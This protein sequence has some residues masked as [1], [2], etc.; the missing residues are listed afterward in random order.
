MTGTV[1]ISRALTNSLLLI[2]V[3]G[4]PLIGS[5]SLAAVKEPDATRYEFL[6]RNKAEDKAAKLRAQGQSAQVETHQRNVIYRTLQLRVFQDWS[7]AKRIEARLRE[8]GIDALVINDPYERGYAVSAG[9]F[10]T[11]EN[12]AQQERKL[13]ELGYRQLAV[14]PMRGALTRYVVL[15]APQPE[16]TPKGAGADARSCAR[17]RGSANPAGGKG[18]RGGCA[19]G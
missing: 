1:G 14:V 15:A 10:L 18:A 19:L 2:A 13:R 4:A 7:V 9:A 16:V 5:Q 17:A 12:L 11:D 3:A 6:D 8:A